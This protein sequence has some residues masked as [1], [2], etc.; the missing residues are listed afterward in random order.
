MENLEKL[1]DLC[2]YRKVCCN[3]HIQ[4]LLDFVCDKAPL[5]L[6]GCPVA[7]PARDEN[8]IRDTQCIPWHIQNPV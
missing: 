2:K 7:K 4:R 6:K 8:F 3:L 5:P 1:E